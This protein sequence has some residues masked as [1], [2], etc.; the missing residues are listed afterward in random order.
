[1]IVMSPF[2]SL[3]R[4]EKLRKLTRL[5]R[6]VCGLS[7]IVSFLWRVYGCDTLPAVTSDQIF[8]AEYFKHNDSGVIK[9]EDAA[10]VLA[11]ATMMVHTDLHN[12]AVRR[13]MTVPQWLSMNRGMVTP[14]CAMH[15]CDYD[16]LHQRKQLL[17][18]EDKSVWCNSTKKWW[19]L[20]FFV[21]LTADSP[22]SCCFQEPMMMK[23]TQDNSW[24]T[25]THAS[26]RSDKRT[27]VRNTQRELGR[28][29]ERARE[30]SIT[31]KGCVYSPSPRS[32]QCLAF[33]FLSLLSSVG[34]SAAGAVCHWTGP[35]QRGSRGGE[36]S[37]GS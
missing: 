31:W 15:S 24:L 9:S 10:Y 32:Q 29:R 22:P 25:S 8:A 5:C 28:E 18:F 34:S 6:W 14:A 1:M 13:H 30:E 37:R 4:R 21:P 7:S 2:H 26:K 36:A 3:I 12:P 16:L 33:V 19:Q 11:F 20:R 23:T 35:H 17:S 27:N